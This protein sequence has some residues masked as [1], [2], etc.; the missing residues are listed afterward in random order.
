MMSGSLPHP[1][2]R[3]LYAPPPDQVPPP[4]RL[5]PDPDLRTRMPEV[6]EGPPPLPMPPPPDTAPDDADL[7]FVWLEDNDGAVAVWCAPGRI[8]VL[9]AGEADAYLPLVRA[10]AAQD[11]V[12]AATSD[13]SRTT[14]AAVR[15]VPNRGLRAETASPDG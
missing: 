10:A 1:R 9:K 15:V 14:P 12:V 4:A 7:V 8:G 3:G 5:L 6:F 13:I 11:Q 2:G